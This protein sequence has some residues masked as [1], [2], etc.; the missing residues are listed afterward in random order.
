[1]EGKATFDSIR[2]VRF[3]VPAVKLRSVKDAEMHVR[4]VMGWY[5]YD[6]IYII[7]TGALEDAQTHLPFFTVFFFENHLSA[8]SG[9]DLLRYLRNCALSVDGNCYASLGWLMKLAESVYPE[10]VKSKNLP[11]YDDFRKLVVE[12]SRAGFTHICP[13]TSLLD[14]RNPFIIEIMDIMKYRYLGDYFIPTEFIHRGPGYAIYLAGDLLGIAGEA[15][16]HF[17]LSFDGLQWPAGKSLPEDMRR[18]LISIVDEIVKEELSEWAPRP[19]D[20]ASK[21]ILT[22]LLGTWYED[23]TSRTGMKPRSF[24]T[25][26]LTRWPQRGDGYDRTAQESVRLASALRRVA[27]EIAERI[28]KDDQLAHVLQM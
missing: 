18:K 20:G 9:R 7:T 24:V 1:M 14:T 17:S 15:D 27:D 19:D 6:E 21:S 11:S 13:C 10:E 3:D 4:G 26:A 5:S 23:Y 8:S 12:L 2:K 28:K 22:L 25:Y 16:V